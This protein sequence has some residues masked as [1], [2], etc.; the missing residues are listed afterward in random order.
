MIF[1]MTPEEHMKLDRSLAL[2]EENNAILRGMRRT[3]RITAIMH[4]LYWVIIIGV[5]VGA[6]YFIQPYLSFLT[7]L[8]L[9]SGTNA[10]T[11]GSEFDGI[12][13]A[14]KQAQSS[15]ASLQDLLK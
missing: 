4:I 14:L 15:G 10:Q 3:Q 6:F 13:N 7:G 8:V 9:P 5:S 1:A 2:A 12:L 11:G